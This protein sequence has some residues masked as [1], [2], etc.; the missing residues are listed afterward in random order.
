MP[1]AAVRGPRTKGREQGGGDGGRAPACAAA[2]SGG[3][4]A[5]TARPRTAPRGRPPSRPACRPGRGA[6]A[7]GPPGPGR[8]LAADEAARPWGRGGGSGVAERRAGVDLAGTCEEG[9]VCGGGPWSSG[10]HGGWAWRGPCARGCVG[11]GGALEKPS[12]Q[13]GGTPRRKA[14]EA[15]GLALPTS[16]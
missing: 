13:G 4:R 5:A 2:A 12:V 14:C 8:S 10:G 11:L 6:A 1:G 16:R 7:V 15:S 9:A 3:K